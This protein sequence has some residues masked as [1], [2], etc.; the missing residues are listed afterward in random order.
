LAALV[1]FRIIM[2]LAQQGLLTQVMVV[3]VQQDRG[4]PAVRVVLAL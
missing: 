4:F 1:G 3:V 2:Q